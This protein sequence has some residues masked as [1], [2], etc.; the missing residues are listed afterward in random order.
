MIAL[1]TAQA[2]IALHGHAWVAL[3][4]VLSMLTFVV[5]TAYSSDDLYM[6]VEL[7]LVSA[8]CV[9]LV[10][11]WFALRSRLRSGATVDEESIIEAFGEQPL[12]G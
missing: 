10:I 1:A 2:V 8:S 11:F 9:A 4:W 5:V 12:E 3:G 7:G 6:R